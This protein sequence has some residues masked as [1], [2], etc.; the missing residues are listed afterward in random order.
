MPEGRTSNETSTISLQVV[1]SSRDQCFIKPKFQRLRRFMSLV[2]IGIPSLGGLLQILEQEDGMQWRELKN[3]LIN[4]TSIVTVVGSLVTAA[5]VSFVISK[6]PSPITA[7]DDS[8]P[9]VCLLAGGLCS[10]LCVVSGLGLVMFLN[11]V[12]PQTERNKYKHIQA[13][14]CCC[15]AGD[16][17]LLAVYRHTCTNYRND[18][19]C[20]AW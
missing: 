11:A 12:Q 10:A 6:T 9:Y 19:S 18:C 15:V 17:I 3:Q 1:I 14:S 16:A 7:W 13:Y 4:R 5:A 2:L 20:L 8:F